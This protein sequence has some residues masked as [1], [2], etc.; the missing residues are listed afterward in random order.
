[1]KYFLATLIFLITLP[2][3]AQAEVRINEIAWMGV[4]QTNGQYGEWFELFNDG[5]EPVSLVGWKLYKEGGSKLVYT[6]SG[7]IAS[8]QYYVVER[9]TASM[10][11]PLVQIHDEKGSFGNNGFAN[12]G[13]HL[14]LKD[15]QGVVVQ[16]LNFQDGWPAGEAVS[17]YTMQHASG[18]WISAAGTPGASNSTVA[19]G[20]PSVKGPLKETD[21]TLDESVT[22]KEGTD[23]GVNTKESKEKVVPLLVR[24]RKDPHIDFSFP[25]TVYAGGI[26]D[27]AGAVTLEYSMPTDGIFVWNMGDGTVVRNKDIGIVSHSYS[28]EGSYTVTLS[29]YP[30]ERYGTPVLWASRLV[31]VIRPDITLS[32]INDTTLQIKNNLDTSITLSHWVLQTPEGSATIPDMTILAPGATIAFS[33]HNLGIGS[34][35]HAA[36][37]TING[38]FVASVYPQKTILTKGIKKISTLFSVTEESALPHEE[39]VEI[40]EKEK[41]AVQ[42]TNHQ[43]KNIVIGLVIVMVL[44]GLLLLER[45]VTRRE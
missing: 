8:S 35:T 28:Y 24:A 5:I 20:I 9:V 7:S 30:N 40:L 32:A 44:G 25:G 41:P 26:Y 19:A 37:S 3:V 45:F 23:T 18:S 2:L 21:Q 11:D 31:E 39:P 43:A 36:L 22:T 16:S 14:V 1:M 10:A 29:Y 38:T 4:S 12:T 34:I 13:E 33:A 42:K 27:F 17:R 15:N 6:F